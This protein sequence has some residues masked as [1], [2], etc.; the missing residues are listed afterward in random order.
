MRTNFIH[1]IGAW[2]LYYYRTSSKNLIQD[3]YL[4]R[5]RMKKIIILSH[6]IKCITTDLCFY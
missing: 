1:C 3:Q 5:Y 4:I 6:A 2:V